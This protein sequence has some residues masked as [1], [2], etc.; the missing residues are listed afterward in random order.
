MPPP[1][2]EPLGS[3]IRQI[4]L[5]RLF[6]QRQ[7]AKKSGLLA[8]HISRIENG[9][10]IPS[11]PTLARL[12]RALRVPFYYLFWIPDRATRVSIAPR[13]TPLRKAHAEARHKA[14]NDEPFLRALRQSA[15]RLN[16][17]DRSLILSVARK[18]ARTK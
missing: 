6:T 4:R 11:L 3:R 9:E 14:K 18:M 13:E 10:R 2:T 1:I 16:A 5:Q 15:S 7:L 12:A 8:S 17:A